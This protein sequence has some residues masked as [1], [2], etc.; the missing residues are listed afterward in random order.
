VKREH[1]FHPHA[2]RNQRQLAL[3]REI[4]HFLGTGRIHYWLRGGWAM[5]F[6][7][8]EA[9]REHDAIW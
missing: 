7:L 6:L 8:G 9:T 1:T 5:D 2:A 4:D 3:L